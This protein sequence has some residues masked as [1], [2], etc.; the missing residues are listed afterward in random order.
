VRSVHLTTAVQWAR[1]LKTPLL[2]LHVLPLPPALERWR[3]EIAAGRASRREQAERT[4]REAGQA[5][6]T[7]VS[8]EIEIREG[9]PFEQIPGAAAERS[10]GLIVLSVG[11]SHR[12]G[13]T[14]VRVVSQSEVPVLVVPNRG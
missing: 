5:L 8:F 9:R 1:G 6:L 12:P 4:L 10:C 2:L 13:V 7:G 3:A 14:A 11:I